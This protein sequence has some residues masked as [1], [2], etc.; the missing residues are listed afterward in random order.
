MGDT[1]F[2]WCSFIHSVIDFLLTFH[3]G[4]M[5]SGNN[6]GLFSNPQVSIFKAGI[7][8]SSYTS[9]CKTFKICNNKA[10]ARCWVR[11][12]LGF[13]WDRTCQGG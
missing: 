1:T 12:A 2:V 6:I 9:I 5:E 13:S 3:L 10:I 8:G 11:S 7:D 4:Q